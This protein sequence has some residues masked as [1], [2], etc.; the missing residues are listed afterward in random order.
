MD[1]KYKYDIVESSN[2]SD[3]DLEEPLD[4]MLHLDSRCKVALRARW[5]P[6][7]QENVDVLTMA[8]ALANEIAYEARKSENMDYRHT[9]PSP[10][11]TLGH[12]GVLGCIIEPFR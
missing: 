7:R 8:T 2:H 11:P 3:L 12:A 9:V 4:P 5:V 1:M 10:S 6:L